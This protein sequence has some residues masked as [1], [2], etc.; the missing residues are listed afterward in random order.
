[1]ARI[2]K[3]PIFYGDKREGFGGRVFRC[4]KFRTMFTGAHLAQRDLNALDQTDGPH[5]KLDQDPR[6]T[7]V[8]RYCVP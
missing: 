1:M 8:G 6:V 7:R 2:R 4:W 3:G 5:F